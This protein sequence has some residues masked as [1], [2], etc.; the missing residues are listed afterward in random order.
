MGCHKKII[1]GATK[2]LRQVGTT[3]IC[4]G[5]LAQVFSHLF[6]HSHLLF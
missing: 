2:D 5:L 6:S 1:K 3:T 4:G